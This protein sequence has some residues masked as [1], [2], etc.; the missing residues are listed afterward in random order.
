MQLSD[1]KGVILLDGA[2]YDLPRQ[3]KIAPLSWMKEMYV[4][5]FGDDPA[6]QR[7]ASPIAHVAGGKHI[8]PFVILYVAD[9]PD[10]RLQSQALADKLNAAGTSAKALP[11]EGKTHM[12]INREFGES[13]DKPTQ[14]AFEFLDQRLGEL[15]K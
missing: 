6:L 13:G 5:V 4:K 12:T 9:R 1:I 7:N 8:P 10:S 14:A 3:I 2:G 11:A 15:D